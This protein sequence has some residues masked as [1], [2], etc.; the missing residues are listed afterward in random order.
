MEARR[1]VAIAKCGEGWAQA[2]VA[3]LLG[4]HPVTVAKW[5]ARHRR[6]GDSG[7]AAKPTPG[8]PRF[9]T[10]AQ[11]RR[12]LR[13]LDQKPTAHGFRTDLWVSRR[14][15]ELIRRKF[16][17]AF[18]PDYLRAWMRGRGYGP[19]KPR[20]RA[21]QKDQP[22]IDGWVKDDW[23]RIEKVAA[24]RAHLVLIGDTGCSSTRW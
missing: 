2:E 11:E 10:P 6:T 20:R 14:V 13:W 19:Q 16:G 5:M 21:K 7:L 18:H 9:L 17:A 22:A 15:A 8:R 24:A 4:V 23:L 12:V 1:R 3:T